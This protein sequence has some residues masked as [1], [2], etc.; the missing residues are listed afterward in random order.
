MPIP[1]ALARVRILCFNTAYFYYDFKGNNSTWADD[2]LYY[3]YSNYSYT[4]KNYSILGGVEHLFENDGKLL[5]QFGLRYSDID[6]SQ[7]TDAGTVKTSGNGNGWVGVL[8][9]QKSFNDFLFGF[10]AHQ[11]ITVSP[12][13]SN[14]EST[15]FIS[16]T[17]YRITSRLDANLVMRFIRAYADSGDDEFVNDRD[18]RTYII[19]PYLSYKAYRWLQTRIGYQFRYTQYKDEGDRSL[20]TNLFYIDLR[21]IPL[22]N[23]VVR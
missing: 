19:S 4:M 11:D 23:L 18:T 5:A 6:S 12:E 1:I 17:K 15:S 2:E 8:E 21:F 14:Y 3:S 9:Y 10:E 13:G 22:R 20:H 7:L 16:R